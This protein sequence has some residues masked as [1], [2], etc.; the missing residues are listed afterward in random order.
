[1]EKKKFKVNENVRNYLKS[2][3]I[4]QTHLATKMGMPV[5]TINK[6]LKNN[7]EI[8]VD[9]LKNIADVLEVNTNIFFED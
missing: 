3:G 1:M 7:R 9:E 6:M 5:S 4:S 8:S 2:K